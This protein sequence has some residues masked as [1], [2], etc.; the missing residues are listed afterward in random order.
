MKVVDVFINAA[1]I[2]GLLFFWSYQVDHI[3]ATGV[4]II[5]P[6]EFAAVQYL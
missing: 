3:L 2:Y 4:E 5:W 6:L 1:I